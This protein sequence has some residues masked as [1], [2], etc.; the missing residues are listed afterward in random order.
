MTATLSL[1]ARAIAALA[2]REYSRLA[3]ARKLSP[4]ASSEEALNSL[5][6]EL[7]EKNLLS[8]ERFVEAL[9]RQRA[10]KY[11]TA[12]VMA[13]L[14]QHGVSADL[15]REQS[16]N[17][18]ATELER[19]FLAWQKKFGQAPASPQEKA[20]QLRFLLSRGFPAAVYYRLAS[21]GFQPPDTP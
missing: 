12:R 16:E 15:L 10:K 20:Q 6:S 3:L 11:G 14:Q 19:A 8:N 4:H 21:Q 1:K 2:Q 17:L 9:S 7:E 5:L 13:E 18:R